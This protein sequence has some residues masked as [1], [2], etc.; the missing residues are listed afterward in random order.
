MQRDLIGRFPIELRTS[1]IATR[2][3]R[4]RWQGRFRSTASGAVVFFANARGVKIIQNNPI[5]FAMNY[6]CSFP[7]DAV[8][9]IIGKAQICEMPRNYF[10]MP[11]VNF[12]IYVLL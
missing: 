4:S 1:S 10:R 7:M 9:L 2:L 3:L 6:R 5:D 12:D 8:H 11:A